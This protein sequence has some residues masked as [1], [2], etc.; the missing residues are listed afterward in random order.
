MD[1]LINDYFSMRLGFEPDE[2]QINRVIAT[3]KYLADNGKTNKEI[4]KILMDS[5]TDLPE[6]CEMSAIDAAIVMGNELPDYLWEN[7]LLK[8][9]VYYY[10]NRLHIT[11]KAPTWNP[12]TFKEECEP[13]FME[14][15]ISFTMEDLLSMYYAECR[16]PVGL[17][18]KTRDEGAMN[19]LLNKY[20][21]LKAPSLDYVLMMIDLASKDIELDFLSN[22]FELENY[23]KEAFI[24]L[25]E[26]AEEAALLKSNVIKWRE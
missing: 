22:P 18:N 19:H 13:F 11:S 15:I 16:V 8:K 26:M 10:N 2:S 21:N 9:G 5:N 23:S 24:I 14:M 25:E 12:K 17:R 20:N 3:A 6:D 4:F 1:K 7:S